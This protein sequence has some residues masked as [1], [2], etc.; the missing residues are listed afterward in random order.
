VFFIGSNWQKNEFR[1]NPY[2]PELSHLSSIPTQSGKRILCSGWWGL[3]RRPNYLGD[4]VMALAWSLPC[5]CSYALP[6]FYPAYLLV[7]LVGRCVND[8]ES[9]K[10]RY[11]ESWNKYTAIVKYRLIPGIF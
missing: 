1:K 2:N 4:L 7:L 5:G 10:Q 8:E 6:Y 11:G 3:V 9:C